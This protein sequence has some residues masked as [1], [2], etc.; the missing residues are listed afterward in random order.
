MRF[1]DSNGG[2]QIAVYEEGDPGGPT[3]VLVHGWPDS[4]VLWNGVV[5]QLA[6]RFRVVRY[7]NRG[8]GRSSAP[9]ST[10]DYRMSCYADDFA[11]VIDSVAP[12]ERVHVLAHDWG[13]AGMWEYLSRSVA[14]DR[15][16][17]FTSI[18][19]PSADHMN[20]FIIGSL[21][22]PYRP[23]QFLKGLSQLARLTYM[24]FFSIPVL[25][26]LVVRLFLADGIKRA[27]TLRDGI[28]EDRVHH[29]ET[30]KRD[31]ATSMKVYGAN[32]FRTLRSARK[33]H[34]VNVPVQVIVN[35]RD[36]FVRPF[37][38]DETRNWVP[39]LWRRDIKSGHWAP[40][41]HAS[42][43][44]T[45]VGEFVDFL[46]GGPATRS[47]LRA[48]VGRQ[49]DSFGDTL[50]SVTGAGSGIGR[51]T[52]LEFAR[53]GAEVVIS[54]VNEAGVKETAAAIAERGGIAHAYTLDVADAD[55][56]E[57]FADEICAEHGVPDIV[58]NNAGVGHTGMFLDT[59]AGEYDRVLDINFGGV[60]NGCRSFGR[61][62]VDRGTGGHIVNVS[63]MAAYSPQQS[64]NAYS[65]SK[66]AVF[67][68]GDCL[69]AELDQAG[70]G[71]TTICPGVIDTDIVRTTRFDVPADKADKVDA[72]RAQI[73]KAFAARRYGPEKVAKAIVSSVQK[74]KAIRPVA[75]EAY[76][77][78]GV[79]RM[80]PQVMRS[81]ARG[82]V[83]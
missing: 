18:S 48:Q 62:L 60:V 34:Y 69:R 30:Y 16:A 70:V 14:S 26:P 21:K 29:S 6:D 28:P 79:S 51:A 12:G 19:G 80:L 63:S 32:Y 77:L 42:M 33:D 9:K 10:S 8:V 53:H 15:I 67:M 73:E 55:A 7:D 44:A 64:M 61:R 20:R 83:L 50:V 59:P 54:D 58:V 82:K 37:V 27:L 36:Q 49:R 11:A 13:S 31:A 52:A 2:V 5:P 47:L 38:Y 43:I 22:R 75:P 35:T 39:R 76:V 46:E 57:R 56:V 81:T 1:V 24:M 65:T 23:R 71:L 4:H 25:A 45:S 41:S 78:Y 17:S 72:R 74:N 68:F 40:M 3:V 66:A